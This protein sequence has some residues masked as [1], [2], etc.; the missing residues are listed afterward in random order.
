MASSACHADSEDTNSMTT[1]IL[2]HKRS[3]DADNESANNLTMLIMEIQTALTPK[4]QKTQ[5]A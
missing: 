4:I 2:E 3:D 1:Q 5:T